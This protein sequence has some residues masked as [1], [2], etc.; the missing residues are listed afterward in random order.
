LGD[1]TGTAWALNHQGDLLREQGD[2][3]AAR[4]L[5]EQALMIFRELGDQVG[6]A[7]SLTD[8][9]TLSS[10]EGAYDT[11]QNLY[12]EA[13]ALFCQLGETRDVTRL[14]EH[15]ACATADQ[16]NWDRAMRVAGA[17]AGLREKFATP[18]PP[19]TKANLERRLEA[20]RQ[21][22][23]TNAAATAWMEGIRMTSAKAVEYALARRAE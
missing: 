17:A 19:S 14:L 22:L 23:T 16:G 2:L 5:Y 18:L 20:A 21:H 8:L 9:G 6:S 13:L 10:D 4:A 7:R 11:A 3:R 1:R 12:A 15:I